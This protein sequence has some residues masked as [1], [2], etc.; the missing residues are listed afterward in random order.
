MFISTAHCLHLNGN[1]YIYAST[2]LSLSL[3]EIELWSVCLPGR[4]ARYL[5]GPCTSVH[6]AAGCIGD[7]IQALGLLSDIYTSTHTATRTNA[8]MSTRVGDTHNSIYLFGHSLG[9]L[10]AFE[11]ARYL[12]HQFSVQVPFLYISCIPSPNTVSD[13]NK[14]IYISKRRELGDTLLLQKMSKMGD[15]LF[16][17]M[18]YLNLKNEN[19]SIEGQE[20]KQ[21]RGR[22]ELTN[23]AESD[24]LDGF[25]H[26]FIPLLRHDLSL[27]ESY[28]T[29]PPEE[30]DIQ[31]GMHNCHMTTI[32]VEDDTVIVGNEMKIES[33][34]SGGSSKRL[35]LSREDKQRSRMGERDSDPISSSLSTS[36]SSLG[37]CM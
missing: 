5:E 32:T 34:A 4:S 3:D 28:I 25:L 14:D 26:Q 24:Q 9:G 1:A 16:N 31:P 35:L 37:G 30:C 12:Y 29:A 7:S 27:L 23:T 33:K 8:G 19:E 18:Y 6:V 11:T 21:A 13:A 15:S 20:S 17:D 22:L 2:H 10:V 36:Y